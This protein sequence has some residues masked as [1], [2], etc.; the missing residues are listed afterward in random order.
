MRHVLGT[1]LF[2]V[3]VA[4]AVAAV[5]GAL[6]IYVPETYDPATGRY[7]DGLGRE[8]IGGGFLGDRSPGLLWEV[9]DI[10]AAA[11][12]YGFIHCLF[13]LSRRLRA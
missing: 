12:L 6:W 8:L 11:I 13:V 10:F 7:F 5:G 1:A 3:T 9:V 4:F 2:W